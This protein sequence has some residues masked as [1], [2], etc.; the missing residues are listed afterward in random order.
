[1]ELWMKIGAAA[2][3]VMM[4]IFIF[5]QARRMLKESPKGS[6]SDWTSALIPL[7]LVVAFVLLLMAIV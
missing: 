5:P 6:A 4:L 2:L 7:G 3:I 1:M